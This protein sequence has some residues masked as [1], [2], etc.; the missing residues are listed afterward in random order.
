LP[1]LRL[2]SAAGKG[3]EAL[4]SVSS[5]TQH[6]LTSGA[7]VAGSHVRARMSGQG[8]GTTPRTTSPAKGTPVS[9]LLDE[10]TKNQK[11]VAF[12]TATEGVERVELT[13]PWDAV[14]DAGH[15]PVLISTEPGEV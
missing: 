5:V 7:A 15:S 9:E 1:T 2:R 6:R 10:P 14:R 12:L 4:R 3:P 8:P 11:T 13:E